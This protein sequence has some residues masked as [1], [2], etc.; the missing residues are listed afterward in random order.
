M[1]TRHTIR[2]QKLDY[3]LPNKFFITIC[4]H[5]HGCYIGQEPKLQSIIA[6]KITTLADFFPNI[7]IPEYTV[8]PNHL[9]LIIKI[10]YQNKNVTL[11]KVI[12][13]LKSKITNSWLKTIKT[14]KLNSLASIWQRNYFEHRIRNQKEY[15]KF[16]KYIKINP[17]NWN[18]DRYNPTNFKA[19]SCRGATGS[20]P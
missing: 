18:K 8:M 16:S 7:S 2:F 3:S 13:V 14:E 6:N 10:K 4:C 5:H 20:R 19:S 11:G 1:N 17:I 12:R 15:D 9:H